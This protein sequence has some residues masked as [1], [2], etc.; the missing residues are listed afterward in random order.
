MY[1]DMTGVGAKCQRGTATGGPPAPSA[2]MFERTTQP[3]GAVT[4]NLNVA[5]RSGWSKQA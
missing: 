2:G 5:F 3:S 1:V 4:V